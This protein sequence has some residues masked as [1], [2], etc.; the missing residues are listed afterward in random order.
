LH[1][2]IF[3][4]AANQ[5]TERHIRITAFPLLLLEIQEILR[6]ELNGPKS[7]ESL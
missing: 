6:Q 1:E 2:E 4:D 5:V 3:S 7:A